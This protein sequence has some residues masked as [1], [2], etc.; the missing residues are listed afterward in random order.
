MAKFVELA[1]DIHA[2]KELLADGHFSACGVAYVFY[3][4]LC[5][6]ETIHENECAYVH[7]CYLTRAHIFYD[8]DNLVMDLINGHVGVR[9]V[10]VAGA[11]AC[12]DE[13]DFSNV[14]FHTYSSLGTG[15]VSTR[16]V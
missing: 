8:C 5:Q 1:V 2:A 13:F 7:M 14:F 10:V 16:K 9:T 6:Q 12:T 11:D 4:V 3:A 15:R